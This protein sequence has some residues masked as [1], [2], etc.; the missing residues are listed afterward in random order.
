MT[1]LLCKTLI[2]D[3]T[4]GFQKIAEAYTI[5]RIQFI[6]FSNLKTLC[7]SRTLSTLRTLPISESKGD[8]VENMP[9]FI[10]TQPQYHFALLC[11]AL[12]ICINTNHSGDFTHWPI[13]MNRWLIP[14]I[15]AFHTRN[16]MLLVA[17]S[18]AT[19]LLCHLCV[20]HV[21][22]KPVTGTQSLRQNAASN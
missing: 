12:Y 5:V 3:I 4:V 11:T 7:L 16:S 2:C 19:N 8:D 14:Q 15:I 1:I 13:S 17:T 21:I 10:L 20:T 9:I 6:K 22:V 18:T